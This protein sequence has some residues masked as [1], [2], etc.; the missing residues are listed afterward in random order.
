MSL[1]H[2]ISTPLALDSY[3]WIR[4]TLAVLL[5]L[6]LGFVVA[7]FTALVGRLLREKS[8]NARYT[9]NVI[10]LMAMAA[11]LP[12]AFA[13]VR[14]P[15]SNSRPVANHTSAEASVATPLEPAAELP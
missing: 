9:V 11:C 13:M 4:L 8:S 2:W 15:P 1:F 10:G 5:V 7:I 6:W 3:L 12:A 14:L